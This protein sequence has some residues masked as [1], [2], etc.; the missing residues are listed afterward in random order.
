[1]T[2]CENCKKEKEVT[3]VAGHLLCEDCTDEIIECDFCGEFLGISYDALTAGNFGKLSVPELSLPDHITDLIFCNIEHLE[4][5]LKKYKGEQS[6][7][8]CCG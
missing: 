7:N 5:Y 2:K 6:V 1:M 3:D 4:A 8:S